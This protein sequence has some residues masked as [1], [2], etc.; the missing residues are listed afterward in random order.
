M[1]DET[2]K[3]RQDRQL[4]DDHDLETW[5]ERV[6]RA[7]LTDSARMQPNRPIDVSARLIAYFAVR[8]ERVFELELYEERCADICGGDSP[9]HVKH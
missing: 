4:G 1:T 6:A 5:I 8:P 9:T 7:V 2:G 3:S